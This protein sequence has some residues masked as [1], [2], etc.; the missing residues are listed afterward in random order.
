LLQKSK[1]HVRVGLVTFA[2]D[3]SII[4]DGSSAPVIVTGDNLNDATLLAAKGASFTDLRSV[5]QSADTLIKSLRALEE[6]GTT[7]LG[8]SLCIAL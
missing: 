3:V 7:A 5:E 8:P 6:N 4:G 2:S 1:P